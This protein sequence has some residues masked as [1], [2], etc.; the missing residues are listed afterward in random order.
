MNKKAILTKTKKINVNDARKGREDA[1]IEAAFNHLEILN[2][3]EVLQFPKK[4]KGGA[5]YSTGT[6]AE[7]AAVSDNHGHSNNITTDSLG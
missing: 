6:M 2:F 7:E 3:D 5:L 1:M 4:K